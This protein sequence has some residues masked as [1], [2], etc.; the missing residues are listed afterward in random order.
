MTLKQFIQTF[1]ETPPERW[2]R[3]IGRS[4]SFAQLLCE[5]PA[6]VESELDAAIKTHLRRPSLMNAIGLTS[7]Q[8]L[9]LLA[10]LSGEQ[11][12]DDVVQTFRSI[13]GFSD[14][15][16]A[17]AW[18]RN[19][20]ELEFVCCALCSVIREHRIEAAPASRIA[21]RTKMAGLAETSVCF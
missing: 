3:T 20:R 8:K 1:G 7:N 19:P 2:R 9:N 5:A 4:S 17:V 10:A 15:T 21:S 12:G 14:S 11:L 18:R 6:F 13:A 16:T